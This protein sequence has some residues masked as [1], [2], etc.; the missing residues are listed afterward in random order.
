VAMNVTA[1]FENIAVVQE[2]MAT[3]A[4]PIALADAPSA[5]ALAVTRGEVRF[6]AVR[7]AYRRDSG[8]IDRLSL[9]VRAGEKIWLVGRSGAGKSTLVNV[10]LRF[11]DLEDG[12]IL[13]DGQD[14]AGV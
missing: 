8:V 14:I 13:I 2:G 12:R 5:V 9:T 4:R 3:I 1:I 6:E 10:L 7:F 11:F